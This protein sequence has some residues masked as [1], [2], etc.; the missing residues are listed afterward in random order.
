M[1][2]EIKPARKRVIVGSALPDHEKVQK[3]ASTD[4]NWYVPF[5][6]DKDY[7]KADKWDKWV[8]VALGIAVL[9]VV[10]LDSA[11]LMGW[12]P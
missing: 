10:A 8:A 9:I 7:I 3:F 2:T 5:V 1:N 6:E 11:W 4:P 12:L